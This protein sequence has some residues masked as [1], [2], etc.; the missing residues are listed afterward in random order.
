MRCE[1]RRLPDAGLEMQRSWSSERGE[2]WGMEG[3]RWSENADLRGNREDGVNDFSL[4]EKAEG[5]IRNSTC[6]LTSGPIVVC[7]NA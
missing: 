1:E 7:L 3:W 5:H 2:G 6:S 4:A